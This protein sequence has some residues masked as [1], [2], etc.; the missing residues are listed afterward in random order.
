[1]T[2]LTPPYTVADDMVQIGVYSL[3]GAVGA[4]VVLRGGGNFQSEDFE[5]GVSGWIIYA[6]GTVEFNNGTFRGDLEANSIT[7]GTDAWHV[8]ADGNMWWGDAASYA[9]AVLADDNYISAAG[10]IN[11][12]AGSFTGDISGATGAFDS[13]ITVGTDAWHV[14]ASG[15]MWWGT[16]SSYANAALAQDPRISSS[17]FTSLTSATATDITI[18]LGTFTAGFTSYEGDSNSYDGIEWTTPYSSTYLAGGGLGA[19][20][21][22][23]IGSPEGSYISKTTGYMKLSAPNP[24][25]YLTAGVHQD[26]PFLEMYSSWASAAGGGG[27]PYESNVARFDNVDRV[28]LG[29]NSLYFGDVGVDDYLNLGT[30]EFQVRIG[31]SARFYVDNNGRAYV[32]GDQLIFGTP[33]DPNFDRIVWDESNNNFDFFGDDDRMAR[34]VRRAAGRS[35]ILAEQGTSGSQNPGNSYVGFGF[36]DDTDTGM[37]R[38]GNNNVALMAGGT[39]TA[40]FTTTGA[41]FNEDTATITAAEDVNQAGYQDVS[42]N[43]ATFVAF[44]KWAQTSSLDWKS[45]VQDWSVDKDLFMQFR[46]TSFIYNDWAVDPET[47]KSY[48]TQRGENEADYE[49]PEEYIPFRRYG[50]V[51]EETIEHGLE[52]V[53]S[54]QQKSLNWQAINTMTLE[55]TQRQWESIESIEER[56][57]AAGL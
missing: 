37:Y 24:T 16:A 3:G 27:F 1:M 45:D 10:T 38:N 52:F 54:S 9:A 25:G 33:D 23:G 46:T 8:D 6:D 14:D 56:L 20:F 42:I 55:Q 15:N 40:C 47:G 17:G 5:P 2:L 7:I 49:F 29:T 48:T 39:A 28:Y 43:G 13:G 51:Y 53:T 18:G 36:Y 34:I 44:R 22:E 35:S 11:F 57:A 32:P 31:G 12:N 50:L 26:P 19:R 41:A 30:S 4:P 21:G